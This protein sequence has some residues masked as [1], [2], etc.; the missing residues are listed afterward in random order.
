MSAGEG[1]PTG[2]DGDSRPTS[3]SSKC[4]GFFD[5]FFS[6]LQLHVVLTAALFAFIFRL[7]RIWTRLRQWTRQMIEE[8]P[9]HPGIKGHM[10]F[11]SE[12]TG[13]KI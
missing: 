13:G 7:C 9:S 5:S 1:A 4:L 6:S 11:S 8:K 10:H 12:S 3:C 2:V